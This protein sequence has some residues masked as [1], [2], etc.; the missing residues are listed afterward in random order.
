MTDSCSA[1]Q[2]I[3]TGLFWS[4]GALAAM[5]W[6]AEYLDRYFRAWFDDYVL[7]L[8]SYLPLA[9]FFLLISAARYMGAEGDG[10][11]LLAKVQLGALFLA[12]VVGFAIRITGIDEE[13]EGH[14]KDRG[15]MPE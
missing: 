1:G 10:E 12:L 3:G 14:G 9:S 5:I 13:L 8:M 11:I 6:V 4:V 2:L 7:A 15:D